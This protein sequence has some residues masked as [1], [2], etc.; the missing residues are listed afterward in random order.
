[1]A[2]AMIWPVLPRLLDELEKARDQIEW[3]RKAMRLWSQA[4]AEAQS[5]SAAG[6][7]AAAEIDRVR[8]ELLASVGERAPTD[9][10][11]A[12]ALTGAFHRQW[13]QRVEQQ[14]R[15]EKAER[16]LAEAQAQII[17]ERK[18]TIGTLAKDIDDAVAADHLSRSYG[19]LVQR[20]NS[21]EADRDVYRDLLNR[22]RNF[23]RGDRRER[24]WSGS[25]DPIGDLLDE[26]DDNL[27][28]RSAVW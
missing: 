1:M 5:G 10:E 12:Y 4:S 17:A 3:L 13:V 6:A 9:R 11:V 25:P 8:M 26:I 28:A 24:G 14:R 20:A 2:D 16:D 23:V 19:W 15:A 27:Q 18:A 21:A 22:L 7:E